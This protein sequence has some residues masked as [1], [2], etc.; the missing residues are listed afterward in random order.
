ML[1]INAWERNVFPARLHFATNL[2]HELAEDGDDVSLVVG[3]SSVL[4]SLLVTESLL[5]T[6]ALL[7]PGQEVLSQ[8]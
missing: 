6:D 5:L 1:H 2:D 3:Q 7:A 8:Q 4:H